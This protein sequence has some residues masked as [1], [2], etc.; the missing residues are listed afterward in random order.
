MKAREISSIQRLAIASLL[1][2]ALVL[3]A[4]GGKD[5]KTAPTPKPAAPS[6]SVSASSAKTLQFSWAPVS[7]ATKY[8]LLKNEDGSSGYETI[9][10]NI[11][12]TSARD[13]ISVHLHD[14]AN[15]RYM[16]EACNS[17][18]CA[19]SAPVLTSDVM[20]NAIGAL[21]LNNPAASDYFGYSLALSRDGEYL[22]VGASNRDEEIDCDADDCVVENVGSV[23]IFH[24]SDGSWS[25]QAELKVA[26]G[27][28][29]AS[30]YFGYVLALS[31]DGELLAVGTPYESS[32]ATGINGERNNA[33]AVES[34][35]VYVFARE[36]S[37]W[38]EQAYIKASNAEAY[39]YFGS[40]LALSEDGDTLFVGAP[41]EAS[42]ATGANGDQADNSRGISGAVYVFE[43]DEDNWTQSLYLKAPQSVAVYSPCFEPS[44]VRC[45][46][47]QGSRFGS[48]LAVTPDL[49]TLVVGA[50]YDH[51]AATGVNGE[52]NNLD[53]TRAG[54]A[55][56]YV[57][58]NAG[59][60]HQAYLKAS[61]PRVRA[62]FG[63]K[64]AI[65]DDGN[66]LAISAIRDNS[67]AQG[68]N[69]NQGDTSATEAGAVYLF[70]RNG[71]SW[72]QTAYLK[73]SNAAAYTDFG[74]AL[75]LS[76]DG[77]LLAV[78][79]MREK[80]NAVGIGG[81]QTDD[82]LSAVG[83]VYLFQREANSW[84]QIRYI[85]APVAANNLSFGNSLALSE[86]GETLAVGA[87]GAAAP[88]EGSAAL[89]NAG[90]V[91]L[92]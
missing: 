28:V 88:R 91:Y 86:D 6:V 8:R 26:V 64:L 7:Y 60:E 85:K 52:Q 2:S 29:N 15:T 83:A 51:S 66:T 82:S 39:D 33:S 74:S 41:G 68:I 81:D 49:S 17:S 34:G 9:V 70:N 38:Q 65:S 72:S 5:K 44:P 32:S 54:A 4:C 3:S 63:H 10:D 59:W 19:S 40:S 16:V 71:N 87:M 18:G 42:G 21:R 79:A 75:S 89:P 73:A 56:V 14:W 61:N 1:L 13:Q 48:S 57:K 24:L 58:T 78:G 31:E 90:A 77:D 37:S 25:Q 12:G 30:N 69:G 80:S 11:T 22:A 84:N 36:G 67:G 46:P 62:H 43:R 23:T 53:A 45:L 20:L 76:A 92:Y 27:A 35:A 47:Y 50:I 55:H